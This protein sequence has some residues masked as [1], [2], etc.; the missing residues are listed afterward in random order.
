MSS[1][2]DKITKDSD[3]S[4]LVDKADKVLAASHFTMHDNS[5]TRI[6]SNNTGKILKELGYDEHTIELGKIAGYIHDIGNVV[7]RIDHSHSGAVLAYNILQ[8]YDELSIGD[9]YDIV[10][11]IGNHDIDT[12]WPVNNI[13]AALIIADKCDVRRSRVRDSKRHD[14]H[15]A[16]NRSVNSYCISINSRQC[17]NPHIDAIFDI[18]C[19]RISDF[20]KLYYDNMKLC[21]NAAQFINCEFRIIMNDN[22]LMSGGNYER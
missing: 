21:V 4:L 14:L 3:I 1:V 2:F 12:G 11:A 22:I 13:G 17:V 20:F 19:S 18:D 8:K 9:I 15:D 7:N 16:V 5:H 10:S 6:V